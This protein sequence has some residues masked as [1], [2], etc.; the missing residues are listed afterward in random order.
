MQF[1]FPLQLSEDLISGPLA[2]LHSSIQESLT[3]MGHFCPRP[4]NLSIRLIYLEI[5]Y[6][7]QSSWRK[8]ADRTASDML[9]FTP[10]L[11]VNVKGV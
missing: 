2:R 6:H 11:N 7:T 3:F 8:I 1:H 9:L 5:S 10:V 4:M